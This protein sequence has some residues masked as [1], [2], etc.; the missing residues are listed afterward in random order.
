M[1]VRLTASRFPMD[2]FALLGVTSIGMALCASGVGRV[3]ASGQW[4]GTQGVVGSALGLGLLFVV[5][6]RLLGRPLPLIGTDRAALVVV[7]AV[8]AIKVAV[9]AVVPLGA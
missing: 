7:V 3:A 5:G 6:A 1:K 4:L 2:R 9:S 8:A